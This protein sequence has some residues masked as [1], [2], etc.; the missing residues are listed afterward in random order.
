MKSVLKNQFSLGRAARTT[1]V[2]LVVLF[3]ALS[4]G[5]FYMLDKSAR[6]ATWQEAEL[7]VQTLSHMNADAVDRELTLRLH[8]VELLAASLPKD[9]IPDPGLLQNFFLLYVDSF[10]FYGVGLLL[11]DGTLYTSDVHHYQV[12]DEG[13]LARAAHGETV[14][15]ESIQAVNGADVAINVM[16]VP[17]RNRNGKHLYSIVATFLSRDLAP[18]LNIGAKAN[19]G[20][21]FVLNKEGRVVVYPERQD[22]S[23]AAP[24]T[25]L[26]YAMMDYVDQTLQ[27]DPTL[28]EGMAFF[29][30]RKPYYA[31]FEPIGINDWYLMTCAPRDAVF[32]GAKG[33]MRQVRI[34]MLTLWA[35]VLISLVA[36]GALYLRHRKKMQHLV[37]DDPLLGGRNFE[38]LRVLYP[39]FSAAEREKISF[40]VLDIDKFKEFNL[41]YG[42]EMGDEL[43]R[44]IASSFAAVLP[45]DHI[46]RNTADQF[47]GLLYTGEREVVVEKLDRLLAH[48]EEDMHHKRIERFS[49]SL[50]VCRAAEYDKLRVVYSDAMIAK[51]TIKNDPLRRYAL[52][53]ADMRHRLMVRRELEAAFPAALENGEFQVYYQPKVETATGRIIGSEALVRWHKP[54]G[55]LVSPGAFIPCFEKGGQIVQLDER[56]LRDVCAQMKE[57]QQQGIEV[58]PVSVNLSRVHLRYGDISGKIVQIVRESGIEP[59]NLSF[60]IT[61]SA[62]FEDAPRLHEVMERIHA[63]GCRVDMDD[64][65]TGESGLRSLSNNLF[66][67]LKLDK[68]FVDRLGDD[69]IDVLIGSTIEMASRLGMELIAEGVETREQVERLHALGCRYVQGYFYSR[70][71]PA[72][73][74]REMLRSGKTFPLVAE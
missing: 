61:E 22:T 28:Q 52:Y 53:D 3:A 42:S 27:P 5:L 72:A 67:V 20:M 2:V 45:H 56:M 21:S 68:S 29:Y 49:V 41:A 14:V 9:R 34:G 4:I 54:D 46:Y 13:P 57:M 64:Y 51:N 31:H 11:P 73:E 55:S 30:D 19:A 12:G 66:D 40:F 44:Y 18:L 16:A 71:V 60:E 1:V 74:Y 35:L 36:F 32:A 23:R 47:A 58:R 8:A 69:R 10:D 37:F 25:R 38:Y 39:T 6:D 24:K 43:L 48:F 63:M 65:G 62:L 17:V 15:S 59:H 7:D 50:G 26:F 70:P 33:I